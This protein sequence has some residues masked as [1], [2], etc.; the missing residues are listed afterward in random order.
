MFF[1]VHQDKKL[2]FSLCVVKSGIQD[3]IGSMNV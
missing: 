1:S 2:F 3:Q